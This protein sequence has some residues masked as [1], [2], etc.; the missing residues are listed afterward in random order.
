MENT[1]VQ[2]N[3]ASFTRLLRVLVL[4][5]G[6]LPLTSALLPELSTAAIRK[7]L[8]QISSAHRNPL[9]WSDSKHIA[10][11]LHRVA[12]HTLPPPAPSP[13]MPS[14]SPASKR[15]VLQLVPGTTRDAAL[16]RASKNHPFLE[17][18]LRARRPLWDVFAHV[19]K[20]WGLPIRLVTL[21]H[22]SI[23][24]SVAHVLPPSSERV[25]LQYQVISVHID[26][27]ALSCI[28]PS[29]YQEGS[30]THHPLATEIDDEFWT[31]NTAS[32]LPLLDLASDSLFNVSSNH[33]E[34]HPSRM[35]Q[36]P[37]VLKKRRVVA[38]LSLHPHHHPQK[39]KPG[40]P[41]THTSPPHRKSIGP[42]P[43]TR[44]TIT[45][46]QNKGE[47]AVFNRLRAHLEQLSSESSLADGAFDKCKMLPVSMTDADAKNRNSQI[48][49]ATD[50]MFAQG[51]LTLTQ[52]PVISRD[53]NATEKCGPTNLHPL[54][55]AMHLI[56]HDGLAVDLSN[57]VRIDQQHSKA[58][59][60]GP[61]T[62]LPVHD[63]SLNFSALFKDL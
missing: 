26:F 3:H 35:E 36:C 2:W 12:S 18:V 62:A 4:S 50:Q 44:P 38:P 61:S 37:S 43:S 17:L 31:E 49:S 42:L 8:R 33:A 13:P 27:S 55:D 29:G 57:A 5:R 30:P 63:V 32:H 22:L 58:T 1:N 21:N 19:Y 53:T 60:A 48:L 23:H 6:S 15:V 56:E 41:R 59:G 34:V 40:R 10:F 9:S 51:L 46:T 45:K 39:K 47:K 7:T 11:V 54:N 24:T 28:L 14:S 20:K 52:Q 25:R 16:V